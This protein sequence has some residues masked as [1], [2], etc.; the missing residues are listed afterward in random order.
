MVA[1]LLSLSILYGLN[2]VPRFAMGGCGSRIFRG[3]LLFPILSVSGALVPLGV[4]VQGG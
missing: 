2:Y 1:A 3:T 4:D